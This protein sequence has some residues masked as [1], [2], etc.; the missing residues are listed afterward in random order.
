MVGSMFMLI[1]VQG[2]TIKHQCEAVTVR[3]MSE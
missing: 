2:M 3:Y 1:F